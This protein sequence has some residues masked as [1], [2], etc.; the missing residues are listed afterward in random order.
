PNWFLKMESLAQLGL[1]AVRDGEVKIIPQRFEKQYFQWLENIRDW[2]ISRQIVWGIRMPIWYN[3]Q[4]DQDIFVSFLTTSGERR[5]GLV[6]EFLREGIT[7]SE[8]RNGLQSLT[9][10]TSAQYVVS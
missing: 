7:L 8:I 10:P 2:P 5:H 1:Q 3:A 4:K 6:E 9:A